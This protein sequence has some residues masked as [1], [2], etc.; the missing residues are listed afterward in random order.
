MCVGV[1]GSGGGG[2]PNGNAGAVVVVCV[3]VRGGGG[4][5]TPMGNTGVVGVRVGV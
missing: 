5:G 4:G 2:I 3:G 1:R